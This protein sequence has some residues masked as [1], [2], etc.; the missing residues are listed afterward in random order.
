M[1][2]L[3]FNCH[4]P[5]IVL[6]YKTEVDFFYVVLKKTK[7]IMSSQPFFPNQS[8]AA[9]IAFVSGRRAFILRLFM[10]LLKV[11]PSMFVRAYVMEVEGVH[12]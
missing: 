10:R 3:L 2:I 9:L 12:R 1:C 8:I 4:S 7:L 5:T 11:R 6:E